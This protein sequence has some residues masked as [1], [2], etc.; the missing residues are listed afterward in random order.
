LMKKLAACCAV[1]HYQIIATGE[2]WLRGWQ[3]P[4]GM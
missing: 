4:G 3:K 1:N 2:S